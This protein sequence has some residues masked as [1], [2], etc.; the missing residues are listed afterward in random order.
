LAALLAVAMLVPLAACSD[1]ESGD[2]GG[3]DGDGGGGG[4]Q[5]AVVDLLDALGND[6]VVPLY[7]ELIET[8]DGLG[9]AIDGL[10]AQPRPAGLEAARTAW[11]ETD[12]AWQHT[13]PVGVGP[14]MD[15]RLMSE[16]DY[17]IRPD[18]VA[19]VLSD[20]APVTPE[21][22]AGGRATARGLGAV[23]L[24]LFEPDVSEA[25]LAAG[26]ADGRRCTYAAA[27]ITLAGTATQGVLDDWTGEGEAT[28]AY[29]ET[30]T[31]GMEDG[32]PQTSL[33]AVVNEVA[34]ALQTIDD[35]GLRGIAAAETV[36]DVPE[37]QRD[38]AAGQRVAD[39]KAL[40]ETVALVVQGPNGDDGLGAVVTARSEETG[41]RLDDALSNA[42]TTVEVLPDSIPDTLAAPDD[43]AAAADAVAELKVV[44]STEVASLLGITI[45]FSDADGDS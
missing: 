8:F 10:C 34:H 31:A 15:R 2:G 13:R 14:A 41:Q 28:G 16:V 26:P 18:D 38:G 36:D 22:L 29:T 24:L 17:P 19:E 42:S 1:D 12:V 45:G 20:T 44:V 9:T 33:S 4:D 40:L 21:A 30:F 25:E 27:A 32:D 43:L 39:L 5:E 7:T 23:E 6:V 35:Q 3:G 37:R 11:R